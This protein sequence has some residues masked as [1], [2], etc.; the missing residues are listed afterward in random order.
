MSGPDKDSTKPLN[1]TAA[2]DESTKAPAS[3]ELRSNVRR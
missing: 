3:T 2:S 1:T